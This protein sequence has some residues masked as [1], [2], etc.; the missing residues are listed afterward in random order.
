M[1][2]HVAHISSD[3]FLKVFLLPF[4]FYLPC[5]VSETQ[6]SH[7]SHSA[8][9]ESAWIHWKRVLLLRDSLRAFPGMSEEMAPL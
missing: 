4:L 8:P 6:Q 1:A 5:G 7:I 3:D 9:T 2:P